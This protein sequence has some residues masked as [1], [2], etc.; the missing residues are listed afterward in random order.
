M[1]VGFGRYRRLSKE[2]T[3]YVCRYGERQHKINPIY[4]VF[5]AFSLP[6]VTLISCS[7]TTTFSYFT[8]S[9]VA[10]TLQ[11]F[12]SYLSDASSLS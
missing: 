5:C 11:L 1:L 9:L 2:A 4:F 8:P 12:I 6:F 10:K 7:L 3:R